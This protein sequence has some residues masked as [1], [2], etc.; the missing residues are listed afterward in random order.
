MYV[1]LSLRVCIICCHVI[2]LSVTNQYCDID[3]NAE[4]VLEAGAR[5]E[6][7]YLEHFGQP[8]L[9]FR[10]E[11]REAYN[12]EKQSPLDH[13]KNLQRYLLMSSLLV[14]KNQ[15]LQAFCIRHPD[16]HP[17]NVIVST[18]PDSGKLEIAS[19][20]DWQH[21]SILPRFLLAGIP[22]RLQNYDDPVSQNLIPP[23]FPPHADKMEKSELLEAIELY[24]ARLVHFHYVK[25][26]EELNKLHHEALSD[27]GSILIRRLFYEAGAP[28]EAE[29]HNLKTLLIEATEEWGKLAG[30]GVGVP[31]PV[32]FEEDD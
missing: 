20:L 6:I 8:L 29:T 9:P 14:P 16:L 26:T 4:A 13:I 15:S 32:E 5:K 2:E 12:F 27:S 17:S 7:A 22:D 18:S 24:H 25:G 3:E 23:T 1:P 10:R 21:A 31:C 11:R 28:W 30:A 19:L